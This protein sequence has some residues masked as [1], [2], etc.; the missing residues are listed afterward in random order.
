M[1]IF[2]NDLS[3]F[4]SSCVDQGDTI[5]YRYYIDNCQEALIEGIHRQRARY[6]RKLHDDNAA[7]HMHKD[8]VIYLQS[9]GITIIR[10][11]VNSPNLLSCDFCL[12]DLIKENPSNQDS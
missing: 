9:E 4:N 11:S 1:Y 3:R 12:F 7:S 5:D 2:Q 6:A 8:I 10:Q